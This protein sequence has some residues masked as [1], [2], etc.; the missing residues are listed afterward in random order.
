MDSVNPFTEYYSLVSNE[1]SREE[2]T[3][4]KK[5]KFHIESGH[6]HGKEENNIHSAKQHPEK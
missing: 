1:S 6:C 3:G 4:K 2:Q 5:K